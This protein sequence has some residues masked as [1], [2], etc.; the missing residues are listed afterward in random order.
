MNIYERCPFLSVLCKFSKACHQDWLVIFS[1]KPLNQ[2]EENGLNTLLS[3]SFWLL[4]LCLI[5]AYKT[6]LF[7]AVH[8]TSA[9]AVFLFLL[10]FKHQRGKNKTKQNSKRTLYP[11]YIFNLKIISFITLLKIQTK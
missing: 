6:T 10:R 11:F 5:I 2:N 1:K 3:D 7:S 4:L 9:A 8:I